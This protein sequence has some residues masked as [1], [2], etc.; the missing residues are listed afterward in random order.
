[1]GV[2]MNKP[3]E[4][5][6]VPKWLSGSIEHYGS[7]VKNFESIV[8]THD[9]GLYYLA[10]HLM[11]SRLKAMGIED[12]LM[13]SADLVGEFNADDAAFALYGAGE[14]GGV[15]AFEQGHFVIVP[16]M[17]DG[18]ILIE[19]DVAQPGNLVVDLLDALNTYRGREV[20]YQ[21]TLFKRYLTL[22]NKNDSVGKSH[23]VEAEERLINDDT[24]T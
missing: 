11:R 14:K 24:R 4:L 2:L 19:K 15:P 20:A 10:N 23:V 22:V 1:M 3:I 21:S 5:R 17:Y 12:F 9:V 18:I 13:P 16:D 7:N 6:F 8:S